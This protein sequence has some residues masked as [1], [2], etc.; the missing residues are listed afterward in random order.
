[1]NPYLLLDSPAD[2]ANFRVY[3]SG[4]DMPQQRVYFRNGDGS[5]NLQFVPASGVDNVCRIHYRPVLER[6]GRYT[7]TVQAHDLSMNASGDQDYRVSFEVINRPTIT[8]VLNYPNPFT[9]NT[10]F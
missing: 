2:T 4:P 8:E 3:L 1:E 9:T 10:R 6:D 5:E 7:L